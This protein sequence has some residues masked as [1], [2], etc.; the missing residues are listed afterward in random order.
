MESEAVTKKRV[1]MSTQLKKRPVKKK[2]ALG[3]STGL[4]INAFSTAEEYDLDGLSQSLSVETSFKQNHVI[5]DPDVVESICAVSKS[6]AHDADGKHLFF[7]REGSV[8]MWNLS[9]LEMKTVLNF[10]KNYEKNSFEESM[11]QNES[12]TMNYIYSPDVAEPEIINDNIVFSRGNDLIFEKYAISNAMALS[13]H[14][15]TFEA[16]FENYINAME[17]VTDDLKSGRVIKMSRDEVLQKTGQLFALRHNINLNSNLLDTPDFYWDRAEL[18]KLYQRTSNYFC[19]NKRTRVMNEK[20]NHCIEL[21]ELLSSHLND[22]HHVRLE[23]MIIILIMVEV[24]FEII[25]FMR[26]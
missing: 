23:W 9:D 26:R 24:L 1:L 13:V 16:N 15:G 21:V 12:E 3:D 2:K 20:I 4:R 5:G 19:I 7:F 11:I 10:V 6:D 17:P 14:L 18:E 25:H 22:K 8:V